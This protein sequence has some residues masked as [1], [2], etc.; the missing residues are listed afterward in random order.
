MISIFNN[1]ARRHNRTIGSLESW[2]AKTIAMMA[3]LPQCCP[4]E[5][6][7]R[8]SQISHQSVLVLAAIAMQERANEE[9][10]TRLSKI[11]VPL[12]KFLVAANPST[13]QEVLTKFY[14]SKSAYLS[15][16]VCC[17]PHLPQ[18]YYTEIIENGSQRQKEL[19]AK[20]P[21]LPDS[22]LYQMIYGSDPSISFNAV[23]NPSIPDD[24]REKLVFELYDDYFDNYY[25]RNIEPLNN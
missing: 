10:L 5:L 14:N 18:E 16:E 23:N 6:L 13:P 21:A 9:T 19:I 15:N 22:L 24:T 12:I 3:F 7:N 25:S 17:N 11:S 20:N 2:T 8:M 4:N 1:E